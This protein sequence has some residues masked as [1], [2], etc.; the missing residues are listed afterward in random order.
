MMVGGETPPLASICDQAL[1][2]SASTTALTWIYA[3]Y[4]LRNA[5]DA[6]ESSIDVPQNG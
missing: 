1:G 4:R 3:A 5:C 2:T 6:N